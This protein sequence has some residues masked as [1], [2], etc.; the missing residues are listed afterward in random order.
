MAVVLDEGVKAWFPL[1]DRL[2]DLGHIIQELRN[3]EVAGSNR[4]PTTY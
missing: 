2:H 4:G 1:P 3:I